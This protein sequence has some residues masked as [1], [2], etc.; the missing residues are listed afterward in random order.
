[1]NFEGATLNDD[2]HAEAVGDTDSS[3]VGAGIGIGERQHGVGYIL[4]RQAPR[5]GCERG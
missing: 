1:M 3:D 5:L 4:G 2:S